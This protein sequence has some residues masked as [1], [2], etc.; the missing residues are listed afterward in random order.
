[1]SYIVKTTVIL[2]NNKLVNSNFFSIYRI[3]SSIIN[4]I[5]GDCKLEIVKASY[6][7]KRE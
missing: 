6:K 5:R 1:M 4:N 7:N 2:L 3:G